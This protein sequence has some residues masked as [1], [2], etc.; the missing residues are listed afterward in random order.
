MPS[1]PC[2]NL[3]IK[4]LV[5]L[6][7]MLGSFPLIQQLNPN[8]TSSRYEEL[9]SQMVKQGNYFQAGCF[10]SGKMVGLTGIWIGTQLWCGK[11]IE[12]DN[13]IVDEAHRQ[14]GIGTK[15]MNWVDEK[16]TLEG[17]GIIR[18]DTYVT[19]EKAHRFYFSNGF[20]IEGFHMTKRL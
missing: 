6:S 19:L 9:I 12:V 4:E 10:L 16:A 15:L 7:S 18:L 20:K 11:F 2:D 5:D 17:C 3:E 1:Q 14:I 8:M 13:F